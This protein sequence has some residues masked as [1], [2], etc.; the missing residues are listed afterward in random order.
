M[1]QG[2]LEVSIERLGYGD[3][4]GRR[5]RASPVVSVA[6]PELRQELLGGLSGRGHAANALPVDGG[7]HLPAGSGQP[8]LYEIQQ[9]SAAKSSHRDG[10]R[11]PRGACLD[12]YIPPFGL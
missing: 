12:V 4:A 9:I 10:G 2:A 11:A 8:G 3:R 5:N 6:G 7:V 1:V